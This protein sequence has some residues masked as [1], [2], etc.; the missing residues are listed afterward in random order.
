VHGEEIPLL[1]WQDIGRLQSEGVEFGSHSASHQALTTL[2][3]TDVVR[4]G[5]RSRTILECELG[6]PITAFAYPYGDTDQVVQHLIGACGYRFGLSCRPGLSRFED[7]LL[8]L[9][10]IEV[11]GADRFQDFIAKLSS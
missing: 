3:P 9:P 1:G 2:S 4:E 6:L 8:A 10:R 5:A 11:T 7:S